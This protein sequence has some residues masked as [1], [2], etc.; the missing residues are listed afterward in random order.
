MAPKEDL[1]A[2]SVNIKLK[3]PYDGPFLVLESTDKT[4]VIDVGGR[5]EC[6]SNDHLKPAH[7]DL[8][9]FSTVVLN[10]AHNLCLN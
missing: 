6:V 1:L 4:F 2:C 9:R 7:R 5:S 10:G 8:S 3:P